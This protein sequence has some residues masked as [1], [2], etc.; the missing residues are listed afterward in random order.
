M[1]SGLTETPC[2]SRTREHIRS[3][4]SGLFRS[5]PM[6]QLGMLQ[7]FMTAV[8][9]ER[10]VS[11][12]SSIS[13]VSVDRYGSHSAA[14]ISRVSMP[15]AASLTCVGKPAP[16]RPTRPQACTAAIRLFLSVTTGGTQARVNRLLAIGCNRNRLAGRT[17]DHA[18]RCNAL[19]CARNAGIDI[20]TDK[21]AGFAR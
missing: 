7:Y 2:I 20:G 1:G 3:M 13:R 12:H 6:M 14:L 4:H 17:V 10:I 16:P 18:E 5:M 15:S 21:A 8:M 19:N 9:P 11:L